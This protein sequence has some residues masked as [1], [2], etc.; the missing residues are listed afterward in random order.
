MSQRKVHGPLMGLHIG[1]LIISLLYSL[2]VGIKRESG[3]Q[4]DQ[5]IPPLTETQDVR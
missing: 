5:I 2:P 3:I 1:S 4:K